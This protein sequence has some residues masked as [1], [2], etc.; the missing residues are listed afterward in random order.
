MTANLPNRQ[1]IVKRVK[2][3][4]CLFG[5][6]SQATVTQNEL[7]GNRLREWR[8]RRGRSLEDVAYGAG[9]SPG[10]LSRLERG[11]RNVSLKHLPA[12]ARELSVRESELISNAL[13]TPVP[14]MGRVG[15]GA[16]IEPDFEQVGPDGLYE[17]E[18]IIPLP[19]GMIGFEVV[20]DSMYPRFDEG[21]VV[22]CAR[23]GEPQALND[24][25]EAAVRTSDGRRFLKKVRREGER[26]RLESHNA[27]PIL[28]V[29]LEWA[30]PVV[31]TV[32]QSRWR[33]LGNGNGKPAPGGKARKE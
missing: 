4:F 3:E 26:F 12:L 20:G 23:E 19:P 28:G 8:D 24:G 22:I 29:G 1:R 32:H 27:P 11:D 33:K 14:V 21:D 17:V 9:I 6:A 10:Y 16:E 2:G 30:S 7:M 31:L 25:D 13:A 18:V 15:A 5:F